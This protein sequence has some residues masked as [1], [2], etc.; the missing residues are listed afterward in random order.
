M[1]GPNLHI[2]VSESVEAFIT[3]GKILSNLTRVK[4]IYLINRSEE[5][6]ERRSD[7]FLLLVELGNRIR[8]Y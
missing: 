5:G 4:L 1:T 2:P 3:P 6:V 7:L 8:C